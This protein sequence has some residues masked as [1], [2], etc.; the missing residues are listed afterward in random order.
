MSHEWWYSLLTSV[1]S[2]RLQKYYYPKISVKNVSK[3]VVVGQGGKKTPIKNRI[4]RVTIL[5]STA[6]NSS[7]CLFVFKFGILISGIEY[8]KNKIIELFDAPGTDDRKQKIKRLDF[9][10]KI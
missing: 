10:N 3:I 4:I 6:K 9:K 2:I 7:V 1:L 5:F 8:I